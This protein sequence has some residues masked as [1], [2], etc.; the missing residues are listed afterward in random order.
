METNS[1]PQ[2]PSYNNV[3]K[4]IG[5]KSIGKVTR[6]E[7]IER[8]IIFDA[9]KKDAVLKVINVQN[10]IEIKDIKVTSG[11][12][13]V[14]GY[15]NSCIM[16]STIKRPPMEN[17]SQEKSSE[18]SNNSQGPGYVNTKNNKS[19][20]NNKNKENNKDKEEPKP[21]CG[22]VDNS[23]ALDGVVRHTTVWIP[24]K[25]FIPAVGVQEGD[26]CTVTSSAALD[27]LKSMPINPIYE[28]EYDEESTVSIMRGEEEQKFIKGIINKSL[29]ELTV[30]IKRYV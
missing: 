28:N 29:I 4:N 8:K 7:L 24:F 5:L 3:N 15:L 21:S 11:T 13:L 26:I 1:N 6:K 10:E 14:N 27:N 23:I 22:V 16:Y 20:E 12:I 25:S 18:N 30:D 9:P 2:E 19:N 17:N